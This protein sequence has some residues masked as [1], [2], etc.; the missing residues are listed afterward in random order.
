MSNSPTGRWARRLAAAIGTAALA[1]VGVAG[2]AGAVPS[3]I[4]P[5]T[6]GAPSSGSLTIHKLEG[7][8]S[9][10]PHN[11]MELPV[12]V[13][14]PLSGVTFTVTPVTQVKGVDIDLRNMG[15]WTLIQDMDTDVADVVAGR[16]YVT[17]SPISRTTGSAGVATFVDLPIGVYLVEETGHGSLPIVTATA[18][19]LVTVPH[20]VSDA[21]G[22]PT[23]QWL[24]DVHIYPKNQLADEPTKEVGDPS[25]MLASNAVVTWTINAP[26]PVLNSSDVL[27]SFVISDD[28]DG[29]LPYI[30]PAR[31]SVSHL[32]LV[33][34]VD[35]S[36]SRSDPVVVT[37]TRSG[38]SKLT[39][40]ARAKG[41]DGSTN[42]V[43]EI[44]TRVL[45]GGSIDN[46]AN[47]NINGSELK[48]GTVSTEWGWIKI[49]KTDGDDNRVAL[50][51]A[52]FAVYPTN[53]DA[54]AGT[55]QIATG[56][57]NTRGEVTFG[58]LW[59]GTN[60]PSTSRDYFLVETQAPNGYIADP[61]V[62]T[63]TVHPS[64][65]VDAHVSAVVNLKSNIPTLPITGVDG[66]VLLI[67][68]GGALTLLAGGVFLKMVRGRGQSQ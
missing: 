5:T 53:A 68:V 33:P 49:L 29:R 57:T 30:S 56:T 17:G 44:D 62:H 38:I 46:T 64:A 54:V 10:E 66:Q 51:G 26:I 59:V 65:A 45:E 28:L 61:A 19:F 20:S 48:T 24:Y 50:S 41:Y 43:V 16:G 35:Y 18:P 15:G 25:G 67:M 11:G 52:T 47:V 22:E 60:A 23:G 8:E 4:P 40:V 37:F 12:G 36:L 3:D 58:P 2:G 31:V 1:L 32:S 27:T 55:H 13:G 9:D 42:V 34:R 14:T 7:S 21:T 39:T 6:E 63:V